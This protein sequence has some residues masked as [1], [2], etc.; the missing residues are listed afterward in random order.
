[1][2]A[3][4]VSNSTGFQPCLTMKT[5]EPLASIRHH[6]RTFFLGLDQA[7][8]SVFLHPLLDGAEIARV[9]SQC[10]LLP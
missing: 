4:P 2:P 7:T 10:L 9:L 3:F 5:I 1:M 6:G 8:L